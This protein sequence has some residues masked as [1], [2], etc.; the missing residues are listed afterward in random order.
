MHELLV[1]LTKWSPHIWLFGSVFG[2]LMS[3]ALLKAAYEQRVELDNPDPYST[4]RF[5]FRHGVWFFMLHFGYLVI[6]ILAVMEVKN[7][8]ANLVT[9]FFLVTSPL[10]LVYRSYDSLRLS[11][12]RSGNGK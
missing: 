11:R 6:G 2:V 1:F 9:L 3:G 10:V 8:W 12:R 4:S 5:W 7:D